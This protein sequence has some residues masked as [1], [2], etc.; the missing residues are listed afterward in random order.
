MNNVP[1]ENA[2]VSFFGEISEPLTPPSAMKMQGTI[3]FKVRQLSRGGALV[4]GRAAHLISEFGEA[5]PVKVRGIGRMQPV[6]PP[7]STWRPGD[8]LIL[9][10]GITLEQAQCMRKIIQYVVPKETPFTGDVI[11]AIPSPGQ[12]G[13]ID[14][15]VRPQPYSDIRRDALQ[16]IG[17]EGQPI[18]IVIHRIMH[19][20]PSSEV[21]R[22][23]DLIFTVEGITLDQARTAQRLTQE[24]RKE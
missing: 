13:R 17:V 3:S 10:E 8:F 19:A 21:G 14:I 6:S 18:P 23:R 24:V 7:P 16:L 9:V 2:Q 1:E 12:E 11:E 20:S 5:Y 15:R 4:N 22:Y